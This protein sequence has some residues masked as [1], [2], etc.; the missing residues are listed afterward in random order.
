[1]NYVETKKAKA[2][3]VVYTNS[4]VNDLHRLGF[5]CIIKP[6]PDKIPGLA[7]WIDDN[8]IEIIVIK[9]SNEPDLL[10][11]VKKKKL[12]YVINY[13]SQHFPE[14]RKQELAIELHHREANFT[15]NYLKR[16]KTAQKWQE[17]EEI[18]QNPE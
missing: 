18:L 4:A 17:D 14:E 12:H 1:M 10:A 16:Q 15:K 9:R 3:I 7:K 2:F 13:N 8:L 11:E 6:D 5:H